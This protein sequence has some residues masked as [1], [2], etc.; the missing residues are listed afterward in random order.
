[1]D[2][3]VLGIEENMFFLRLYDRTLKKVDPHSPFLTDDQIIRIVNECI[4][5]PWYY[6]RECARIPDQGGTGIPYQLHR[7]NLAAT[8]CYLHGIDHYFVVPRQ[9]GKTQSQIAILCWTFLLGT[10]NSEFMFLNMNQEEANKNLDRLRKQRDL[11]P[12]YLQFKTVYSEEGKIL[13]DADNV[14]TLV[15]PINNNKIIAKP[16]A[17][18]IEAAE[19][20][21]RGSTQPIHFCDEVDFT[22][23]IK[24]IV[25]AAGMAYKTASKNAKRNNAP[26]CRIFSS[27]PGDLD[28]KSGQ[29]ASSIIKDTY[30]WTEKFYDKDIEDVKET[31]KRGCLNGIVYIEYSYQQL[32]EDEEWFNESCRILLHDKVKIRRELL[33]QRIRGSSLSPFNQ[34]DLEIISEK[35]GKVIEEIFINKYFRLDVYTSLVRNKIY[36][37][38]VDVSC[39]YGQ[40]NTA[41]TVMD[42]YTLKP[43]AEFKS[44]FIGITQSTKLLYSLIK[45]Y[46]PRSILIIERNVNGE[47]ILDALRNTDIMHNLYFDKS[48]DLIGDNIDDKIDPQG[49]LKI[50]AMRRKTYGVWTA[51]KSRDVMM[52]LLETHVNEF[53]D[54]FVGN[55]IIDDLLK[56]VKSTKG[57][58][59]AE[60]GEHDDSIMSYLI[61]LYV[62]YHGNNLHCFGFVRGQ[63]PDEEDRNKGLTYD[64][65]IDELSDNEKEFFDTSFGVKTVDDYQRHVIEELEKVRQQNNYSPDVRF[66]T[67]VEKYDDESGYGDVSLDLF[68]ELNS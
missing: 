11:L 50:E 65:I 9:K 39:G 13:K 42:P 45:K 22:N 10:T 27:T 52:N 56:L 33:L 19:K 34:E 54:N 67:Y 49:F 68:D 35:R 36:F 66:T 57:K 55:N 26:Y 62:Y 1:M 8:W 31:I 28:S 18:S 16:S 44:P 64:E 4:I 46:L 25:Q 53:K 43:V 30:K 21:G 2:L 12:H 32:G 61:G 48:R 60:T 47:S 59:L 24:T 29:E 63:L 6:L 3:H 17:K 38:S 41:I 15:N 14:K 7:G 37:V 40:D 51:G 58:I 23:Y 5:N 20:I